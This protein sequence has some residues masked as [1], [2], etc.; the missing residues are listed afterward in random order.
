MLETG[1]ETVLQQP[2]IKRERDEEGLNSSSCWRTIPR[3]RHISSAPWP[4]LKRA[5]S[6]G[7]TTAWTRPRR[8]K[9]GDQ[10]DDKMQVSD[11]DGSASLVLNDDEY[12]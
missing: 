2:V 6:G 4:M 3:K 12:L 5:R 8:T 1:S 7:S 10:E 9:D 11:D